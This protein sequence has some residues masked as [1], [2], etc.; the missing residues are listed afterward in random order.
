M[1]V[2]CVQQMGTHT[3]VHMEAQCTPIGTEMHWNPVLPLN[4]PLF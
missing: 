1:Q 4:L 3:Q 2:C